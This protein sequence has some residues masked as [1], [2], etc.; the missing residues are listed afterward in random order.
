MLND[1]YHEMLGFAGVEIMRRI[2]GLAHNADYET[3]ADLD[4]RASCES[5][6]LKLGRH[7][8]V[9][10]ERIPGLADVHA[11]MRRLDQETLS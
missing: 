7:L 9:N 8:T 3:I 2:L 5:K 10:R 1:I 11:T 4:S 6:A